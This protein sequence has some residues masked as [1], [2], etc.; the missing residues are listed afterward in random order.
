MRGGW[1]VLS[2][3]LLVLGGGTVIGFH[4]HGAS[5]AAD[6]SHVTSTT[7]P[8]V[9]LPLEVLS[10]SP[11]S[12]ASIGSSQS[13]EVTFSSPI[14][15]SAPDPVLTPATVGSW[16]QTGPTTL[17][18][19]PE[20]FFTPLSTVHLD[21][22]A[23]TGGP[24]SR[25]GATLPMPFTA[26]F[27]VQAPPVLRLQ[28]LLAEMGYLPLAFEPPG[29]AG[30]A[31]VT[32]ST[33]PSSTVPPSSTIATTSTVAPTSTIE[34]TS[35][36]APTSTVP[37]STVPTSTTVP[38]SV[39]API[40]LDREPTDPALVP[41]TPEAGDFVWRYPSVPASLSA[42]WHPG[43]YTVLTQGA[44]MAFQSSEGLTA[45]GEIT[46]T[47][48]S[49][50]LHAVATRSVNTAAYDFLQ[51]ATMIPE[52]LSIWQNGKVVYQTRANT[53][54]EAAP[55][56]PGTY[57]V[58]ARYLSTTMSGF[59]PDGSHY[60]DPGIPDVAY[61]NGGDAVHGFLRSQYGFPQSLGCVELT[62]SA[63]KVVYNYDPIGTLV[64]I[65]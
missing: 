26:S 31:A 50:L 40:A 19:Q 10:T 16:T 38:A 18:F 4:V 46:A 43:T 48:W 57:P 44:V 2:V 9:P 39:T 61:F 34:P 15:P 23:G 60:E 3:G 53:G 64:S 62:Y 63:A 27:A 59:N 29:A 52:T 17:E 41:L 42:L 30:A 25:D 7:T 5:L 24:A 55:T 13:L 35:T 22:A 20:Q 49:H 11:A 1:A 8:T 58:Y 28:Q 65:S 45:D 47:L 37:A 6:R 51:V 21:I 56:A 14:N 33:L 12:G 32:T 36:V 54:I